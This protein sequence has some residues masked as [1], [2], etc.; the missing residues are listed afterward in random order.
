MEAISKIR[1]EIY[2]AA[3]RSEPLPREARARPRGHVHLKALWMVF[4]KAV[5]G[6]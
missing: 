5:Y 6:A 3:V 4:D 1:G 2:E